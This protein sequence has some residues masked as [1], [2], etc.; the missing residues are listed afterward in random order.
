MAFSKIVRAFSVYDNDGNR[1]LGEGTVKLPMV[2]D[3]IEEWRGSGSLGSSPRKT[4]LEPLEAEFSFQSMEFDI[5]KLVG[6]PDTRAYTLRV[7]WSMQSAAEAGVIYGVS[8]LTGTGLSVDTDAFDPERGIPLTTL[9]FRCA[10]YKETLDNK[11]L[12]DIDIEPETAKY[13]VDGT[14]FW[15]AIKEGL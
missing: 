8:E 15:E 2:A 11:E 10:A 6:N 9:L 5:R 13:V 14:D 1:Y 7:Q 3:T 12:Y 4:G